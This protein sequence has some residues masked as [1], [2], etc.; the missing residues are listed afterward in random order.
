MGGGG[1]I[2]GSKKA[3][4]TTDITRQNENLCFKK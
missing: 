4:E 2:C 3:G 1:L